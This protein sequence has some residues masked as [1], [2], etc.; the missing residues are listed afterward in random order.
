MIR[1]GHP[2][3]VS[4]NTARSWLA[5]VLTVAVALCGVAATPHA[6]NAATAPPLNTAAAFA[7]LAGTTVTNTGPSV[8]AGDLGVSPGTA[9]TGFPPGVV[10]GT[11]H[12][13][14]ATAAQ[15]QLD[16]TA[17]YNNAAGQPVDAT[18]PTELGGTIVTPGTYDSAAGT[19]GITGELTLDGQGD[20]NAVFIFKTASTLITASA[21]R[22][23]LINGA[24]A[25][26]VFWQVGSSATL[27]TGS[28][29]VGN[30]LALTSITATTGVN[31][32]GRLLA[33]NGAVTLDTNFVRLANCAILPPRETATTLTAACTPGVPGQLTLTATVTAS[34]AIPPTGTVEFF[35]DGVSLGTAP[36]A[37][38]GR[39]VLAVTGLTPGTHQLVAAYPGNADLDP[40]GSAPLTLVVGPDGLCPAQPVVVV[41]RK[42]KDGQSIRN[43]QRSDNAIKIKDRKRKHHRHHSWVRCCRH[44]R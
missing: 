30:I 39:A 26:N 44:P 11:I 19:F 23:N 9:V 7:V 13:A 21:S 31:V 37:A 4:R 10:V 15:A 34:G 41:S 14:D 35:S 12:S 29:F 38:N 43:H 24:Q 42:N 32:D 6:A 18:L 27:G 5:G 1:V 36:I 20:P 2:R 33:R 17:A 28:S 16:L 25:C 22:I 3:I 8:I 40:S